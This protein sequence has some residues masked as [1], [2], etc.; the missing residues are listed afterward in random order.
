MQARR[1]FT[2]VVAGDAGQQVDETATFGGWDA[3]LQELGAPAAERIRLGTSYRCPPEVTAWARRLRAPPGSPV[4]G[5]FSVAT[6]ASELHIAAALIELLRA[7]A[8]RDPGASV[9]VICRTPARAAKLAR[10]LSFGLTVQLAL[11]GRFTFR[12]G[13]QVTCVDEVKG[14]EFDDVVVPDASAAVYPDTAPARRALYVAVTRAL[15]QV[16]LISAGAATPL[17]DAR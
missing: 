12:P 1:A 4:G 6:L 15:R 13:V 16:V 2:L 3:V 5:G 14:L 11:D 10:A 9:A 7:H 17:A 8:A